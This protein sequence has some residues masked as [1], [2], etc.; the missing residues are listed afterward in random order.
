M[1]QGVQLSSCWMTG[2]AVPSPHKSSLLDFILRE[3]GSQ[4]NS[5]VSVEEEMR[6]R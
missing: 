1:K 3:V 4:Y 2:C 6:G 5:S